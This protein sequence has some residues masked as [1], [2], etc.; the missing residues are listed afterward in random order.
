MSTDNIMLE[1]LRAIRHSLENLTADM[2]EVKGR[3]GNMEHQYA[4]LS[5]RLDRIDT[6]VHRIEKR[7][8]LVEA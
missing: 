2:Q 3:L 8:D 5:T 4:G 6:R 1:H 7:L